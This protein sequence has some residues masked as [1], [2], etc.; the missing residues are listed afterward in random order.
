[1]QDKRTG[2]DFWK[3]LL[4]QFDIQTYRNTYSIFSQAYGLFGQAS[5][6][7]DA[8]AF[9]AVGLLCR[10]TV[11]AACYLYLTRKKVQEISKSILWIDPP[12]TLDGRVRKVAFPELR[13]GIRKEKVLSAEQLSK[14]DRIGKHGD[15]IAHLAEVTD[16][17]TMRSF[18]KTQSPFSKDLIWLDENHAIEDMTDTM[19]IL[20][21]LVR[22]ASP[23]VE[24]AS[25]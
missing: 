3:Q 20:V 21:T 11:E 5:T 7:L 23:A 14:L 12:M 15:L 2:Q 18:G 8:K 25:M 6:I 19:D 24:S 13:E 22:A 17:V 1:L 9:A 10:S 4:E 16:R